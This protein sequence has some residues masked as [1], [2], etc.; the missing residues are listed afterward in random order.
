MYRSFLIISLSSLLLSSCSKSSKEY[1]LKVRLN[2]LTMNDIYD[3]DLVKDVIFDAEEANMDSIKAKS[4]EAFLKG[5]DELKNKNNASGAVLL[6][7]S[8]IVKFPEAKTY[9]ELGNALMEDKKNKESLEEAIKAYRVARKLD[10][11][12]LYLVY[13]KT[14]CAENML[15]A[16][17]PDD[18]NTYSVISALRDAFH[19]GFQDTLALLKDERINSIVNTFPYKALMVELK[20]ANL[21]ENT[22]GL[23]ELYKQ[24]YPVQL[25]GYEVTVN[26][27]ADS[28]NKESISYDFAAFVPEMQNT[29]FGRDVSNDFF[30]DAVVQSTP[31][32]TALVYTSV[33]FWGDNESGLM[34]SYTSL[35]TYDPKGVIIDRKLI[36][37]QCSAEKIK[38]AS[39]KDNK[40]YVEDYKRIWKQP[41]DK[42]PVDENEIDKYESQAKLTYVIQEDGTITAAEVPANYIDTVITKDQSKSSP[43]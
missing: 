28:D 25:T 18:D 22:N 5:V 2:K 33:S 27:V 10:I 35:V 26:D 21:N 9:Y 16:L 11:K 12:P 15:G 38:T 36:A 24:A 39:I 40:V 23:F 6:F 4:R 1:I 43:L 7:K 34:P 17:D 37:C 20:S 19:A 30:Y 29:E 3:Y 32:Y 31:A 8:S 42:T 13:Y 41:I 14:A